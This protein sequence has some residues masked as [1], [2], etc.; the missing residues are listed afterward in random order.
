MSYTTPEDVIQFT[1]VKPE[2]FRGLNK[3]DTTKLN[4]IMTNWIQ[5]AE[6]LINSYCH[7]TFSTENVNYAAVSN[8]CLRLVA[9][10][11]ALAEA[12]KDTPIVKYN[13][14]S[15]GWLSSNIFSNDLKNDLE[16]FV[17]DRSSKSDSIDFFAITGDDENGSNIS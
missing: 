9:N 1:G 5:Q 14:W 7:T 12:R 10:M 2:N 15:I 16:P 6:G 17:L 8:V 11:V 3:D 4:T 13:D